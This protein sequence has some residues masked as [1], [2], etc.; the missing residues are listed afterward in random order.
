MSEKELRKLFLQY[1]RPDIANDT[2]LS[3]TELREIAI[4]LLA[5]S[6]PQLLSNKYDLIANI[7]HDSPPEVGREGKKQVRRNP[8]EEGTY[9]CH[10]QHKATSQWYEIQDLHVRE[11]MPQLIA[12]SES[13]VLIFERKELS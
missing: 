6:F 2:N 9:R 13:Y 10:V 11:T 1:F 8:L 4:N 5:T 3:E 7:T 12:I